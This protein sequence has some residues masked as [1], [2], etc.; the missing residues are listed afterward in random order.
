[1]SDKLD[2]YT[3]KLAKMI[4]VE[5]VSSFSEPD[6]D[7]FKQFRALLKDLFPLT[8]KTCEMEEFEGSI[9]LKW[10]GSS[11]EKPSLLM[12]HYD[13]VE[14]TGDWKYPPFSGQVV[15]GK[16]YG[17]GTLDDKGPLFAMLQGVEEMIEA[18]YTPKNDIYI[19]S[20]RNEETDG[21]GADAISKALAERG[22]RIDFVL[23][24]GGEIMF[25]P[26][27]GADGTFA[28]VG[29]GEKCTVDLRFIARST[30]GHASTP[31]KNTPL[32]RLGKFMAEVDSKDLFKK[33]LS[34]VIKNM[35]KD[36]APT[37]KGPLG[38][39]FAHP[40]F[41]GPILK[42]VMPKV[43]PAAKALLETTIAF[44]MAKGS[45]GDN[46]LPQEAYVI[47][48]MRTSHH[49][50]LKHSIE[51]V[52]KIAD[53]YGLETEVMGEPFESPLS[54]VNSEQYK[55]LKEVIKESFPNVIPTTY[56]MNGASDSKYFSRVSDNVF[57][58]APFTI[59]GQ[60]LSSIHGLDENV[61]I[62]TLEPAVNFYRNLIK[63]L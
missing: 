19:E 44:T 42:G 41:F 3:T 12:N 47:A 21:K 16:L 30:G 60:Q 20:G 1:M 43:S 2:L 55:M 29:L 11:S 28:V 36:M 14:A 53:K 5:T 33:S 50:G 61:N 17:R 48:N 62:D 22:I 63:E 54:D 8:F 6:L 46:V 57:R 4:Q 58:F 27:G 37:V 32:V 38:F 35:F 49:E 25:D 51:A 13:V 24:E 40:T 56:I 23:D 39:A 52:K 18:G 7:K 9:L 15:D 34:P 59:D 45:D 31:G 26:L 10:K